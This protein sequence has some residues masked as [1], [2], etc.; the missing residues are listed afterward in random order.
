M[1]LPVLSQIG[2][3]FWENQSKGLQSYTPSYLLFLFFEKI[4]DKSGM[5]TIF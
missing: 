3:T 2:Y 5:S 1:S 4:I